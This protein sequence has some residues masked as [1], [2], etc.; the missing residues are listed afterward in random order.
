MSFAR[1]T[2]HFGEFLQGRL[3]PDGPVVLV[4]LPCPAVRVEAQVSPTPGLAIH[5]G[6]QRLLAPDHARRFLTRLGLPAR[7]RVTLRATMPVGGG[8][9]ASTAALVALARAMGHD[10][11]AADL[12]AAAIA[13]EGA[14]DPLMFAAPE[15]LLWASREG[16]AVM[17]MPPLPAFDVLGGFA[18]PPERTR[19]ADSRFPDIS[20]LIASWKAAARA[21]DRAALARLAATS[22]DRTLAL[23]GGATLPFDKIETATGALGHAI[24]HTG[25]ARALLFAPGTVP[26]HAA[27]LMREA[28]CRRVIEFRTGG[29]P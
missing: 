9:G 1:A 17:A 4:T 23:R 22:A 6:G 2:G 16:R 8:A 10:G 24:A 28:G 20:D 15:R 27:A 19:A 21:G 7:G 3:G 25:S 18:G 26:R 14:S 12:A 13:T 11:S 5:G 29:R